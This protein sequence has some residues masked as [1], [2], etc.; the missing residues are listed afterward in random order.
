[1]EAQKPGGVLPQK[2]L[3]FAM[4]KVFNQ[5]KF[6][7]MPKF[8]LSKRFQSLRTASGSRKAS[9]KADISRRA[10]ALKGLSEDKTDESESAVIETA[11]GSVSCFWRLSLLSS[12]I[13]SHPSLS[14]SKSRPR[15]ERSA[16]SPVFFATQCTTAH[17]QRFWEARITPILR[18]SSTSVRTSRVVCTSWS[19]AGRRMILPLPW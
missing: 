12:I 7:Y 3:D 11:I 19:K 8:L 2:A 16:L 13:P 15:C 6:D 10:S 4:D 9:F 5:L 17:F 18:S 1:M 14:H